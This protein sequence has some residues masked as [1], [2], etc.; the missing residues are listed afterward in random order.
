MT[1]F[2]LCV[3]SFLLALVIS[4]LY[5]IW[6]LLTEIQRQLSGIWIQ[7]TNNGGK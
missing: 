3:L 2:D 5:Y 6:K 1:T 7:I 4:E